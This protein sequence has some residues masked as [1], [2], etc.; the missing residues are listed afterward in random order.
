MKK[1]EKQLKALANEKRLKALAY[2]KKEKK[3]PVQEIAD[4]IDLSIKST[5][6]HLAVLKSVDLLKATYVGRERIYQLELTDKQ[7]AKY[8]IG[9]L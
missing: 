3:A 2:L 6:K 1:I 9:L 5:S 4:K 8:I 7:P